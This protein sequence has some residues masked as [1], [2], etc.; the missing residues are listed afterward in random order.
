MSEPSV[1]S[2]EVITL[3]ERVAPEHMEDGHHSAQLVER[4]GWA[5]HDADERGEGTLD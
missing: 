5:I 2:D 3:D 1:D 4:V